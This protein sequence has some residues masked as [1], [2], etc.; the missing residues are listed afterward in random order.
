VCWLRDFSSPEW[1]DAHERIVRIIGAGQDI[2]AQK[3]AEE[4]RLRLAAI[5]DSSD[6]AIISKS[7]TGVVTS[8]NA[9]AERMFGYR[10][11]EMIGQPIL[12]LLPE[13]RQD[14][15]RMILAPPTGRARGSFRDRA[16]DEGWA[17]ARYLRHHLAAPGRKGHDPRRVEDRTGRH[18]T[19]AGGTRP[20][21]IRRKIS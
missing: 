4:V 18:R 10:A 16:P 9:S 13:D 5:V 12:R 8:W 2:T 3:Q 14:E 20:A 1:D 7:L 17:S 15:E 11:E 19:A 21:C 6:D